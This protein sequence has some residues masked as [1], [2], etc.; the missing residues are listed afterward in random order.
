[1]TRRD[2]LKRLTVFA[3]S[4]RAFA[5]TPQKGVGIL[6]RIQG[7]HS[8]LC[9]LHGGVQIAR[10]R[11]PIGRGH[12]VNDVACC[13]GIDRKCAS[14]L[15]RKYGLPAPE[16]SSEHASNKEQRVIRNPDGSVISVPRELYVPV[17]EARAAEFADLVRDGVTALRS[18]RASATPILLTG[19]WITGLDRFIE[20]GAL[21]N[22]RCAPETSA[23]QKALLY[24]EQR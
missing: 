9:L 19:E 1:M 23:E 7:R 13:L 2:I 11:I 14:E 18:A 10:R 3:T 4:M 12:F 8:D 22:A 5:A 21:W 15:V 20:R 6:V 16:A 24:L 17:V